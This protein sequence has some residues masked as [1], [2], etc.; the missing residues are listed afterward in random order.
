M[1]RSRQPARVV[2]GNGGSRP[3]NTCEAAIRGP[4][5]VVPPAR[6]HIVDAA[7]QGQVEARVPRAAAIAGQLLGYEKA[8]V[9]AGTPP[10]CQPSD[11]RR[12]R[13]R[14]QAQPEP[15]PAEPRHLDSCTPPLLRSCHLRPQPRWWR[16][17]RNVIGATRAL[18]CP[19]VV[20]GTTEREVFGKSVTT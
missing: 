10:A 14:G 13:R 19:P 20:K 15:T 4:R 5:F 9:S 6:G 1:K 18:P 8:E 16:S 12:H 2:A 3:A 17:R 11:H 7:E